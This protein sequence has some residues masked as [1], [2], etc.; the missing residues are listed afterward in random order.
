MGVIIYFLSLPISVFL[1]L[2]IFGPLL[3]ILP[4]RGI[5]LLIIFILFFTVAY[6][7]T[8]IMI[9][10]PLFRSVIDKN[11]K[12]FKQRNIPRIKKKTIT[13]LRKRSR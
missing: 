5:S 1:V 2:I 4:L 7:L 10:N 9:Y 12:T 6:A 13:K 11:S 3:R 8:G